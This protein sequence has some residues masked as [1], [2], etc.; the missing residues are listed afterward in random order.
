MALCRKKVL[1]LFFLLIRRRQW[2]FPQVLE[3]E[4]RLGKSTMHHVLYPGTRLRNS[5]GISAL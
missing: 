4:P 2:F 5:E 1:G 3:L